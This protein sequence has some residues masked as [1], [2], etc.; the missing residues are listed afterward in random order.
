MTDRNTFPMPFMV[1]PE[2]AAR[3]IA[4][5]IAKD[6]AEIVFP[7]PMM[8]LMKAARLVPVRLYTGAFGA[9]LRRGRAMGKEVESRTAIRR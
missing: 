8:L 6:K 7:L 1:S 5:G 3:A 9:G 4:D 2:E